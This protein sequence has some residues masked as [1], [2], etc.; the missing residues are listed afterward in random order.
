MR[1]NFIDYQLDHECSSDNPEDQ[2]N[3]PHIG[4]CHLCGYPGIVWI[5]KHWRSPSVQFRA[6]DM[7]RKA[8]HIHQHSFCNH[9]AIPQTSQCSTSSR[10]RERVC[11]LR[12]N[13]K[14]MQCISNSRYLI[15]NRQYNT[16]LVGWELS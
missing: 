6:M 4:R 11:P 14:A 5:L 1:Y 3:E 2:L 12:G 13:K 15:R 9:L 16:I 10:K 7:D 8:Q